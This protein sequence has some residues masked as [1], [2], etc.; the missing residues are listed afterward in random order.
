MRL[1]ILLL[2]ITIITNAEPIKTHDSAGSILGKYIGKINRFIDDTKALFEKPAFRYKFYKIFNS[3][4]FLAD[5]IADV[6][7]DVLAN[8]VTI[9]RHDVKVL[10]MITISAIIFVGVFS[11]LNMVGY[12]LC[13][14]ITYYIIFI[15]M[16]LMTGYYYL[17]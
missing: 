4:I 9:D 5:E 17:I 15:L 8:I 14:M 13:S 6:I 16:I 10:L 1:L 2:S 3:I 7:A 11:S 12:V